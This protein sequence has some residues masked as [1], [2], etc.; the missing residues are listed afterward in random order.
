MYKTRFFI[1]VRMTIQPVISNSPLTCTLHEMSPFAILRNGSDEE[2]FG[3]MC[4]EIII[5]A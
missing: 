2:S 1:L 4:E 5:I 3:Q